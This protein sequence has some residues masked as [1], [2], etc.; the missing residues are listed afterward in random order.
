[1]RETS[2]HGSSS[3]VA[4]TEP[5]VTFLHDT[6]IGGCLRA[7]AAASPDVVALV[8]GDA[9]PASRRRWTYAELF[10]LAERVARALAAR[11]DPGERIA[12]W[13][14]TR[15]ESLVLTYATALAG[16]VLVPVNPTLRATEAAHILSSSGAAGVFLQREYRGADLLAEL[17]HARPGLPALREHVLLDDWDAFLAAGA[18][19][20]AGDVLPEV[21]PG[22]I[23]QIVYTSGTTGTPKGARLTHRGLTNAARVAAERFGI[24]EGDVYV[25][26]LPL[27][28]V[29]G[30]T[31]ALEIVQPRATYVMLGAFDPGAQLDLL[32]SERATL[33][34]AVPTVL[35]ALL[36]DPSLPGRDLGALRSVSSGGAVVPADLVRRVGHEIGAS[37]TIVFGMTECSG[38]VSQTLLDDT[39]DDIAETIGCP[40]PGVETRVVDSDTGDDVTTG[41]VGELLVR[42]YNVMAGYHDRPDATGEAFAPGGWFRT[43]DLVTADSRGYL[44]IVG[45]LKDVVISGAENVYPAEVEAVLHEHPQ[46]ANVAVIGLPDE[47]WGECVTAVI[48]PTPGVD[49]DPATLERFAGERLARYKVPRRWFVV[50]DL[51]LTATGKVQKHVLRE[52]LESVDERRA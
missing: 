31:V 8:D 34:V 49:L 13:S 5:T 22:D 44:R 12:V 28:Y 24:R 48:T 10:D 20:G 51:P 39:P 46:V 45:R 27:F 42:G 15:P 36:D 43:G 29:G 16:L 7:A 14:P 32:E 35:R 47:R 38:F 1:M 9:P 3:S 37:V 11:F 6:T 41:Q 33:T 2:R 18:R 50:D 52:Q 21:A 17:E 40:L 25:D 30:Q 23:A 26:P 4:A 19:A